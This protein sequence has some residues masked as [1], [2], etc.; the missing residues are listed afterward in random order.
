MAAADF[1]L[2]GVD[3][4]SRPAFEMLNQASYHREFAEDPAKSEYFVAVDWLD[5][6]PLEGA[7]HQAGMFGNTNT[8]CRPTTPGW[9][10][11]VEKLKA[12]FPNHDAA[13][14]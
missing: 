14:S 13:T 9:G 8:V 1:K 7:I 3:G 5:T 2:Q 11:T 12:V 6:V 4:N 10:E